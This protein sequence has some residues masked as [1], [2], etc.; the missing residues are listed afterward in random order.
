MTREQ[1]FD[2]VSVGGFDA[3]WVEVKR[4]EEQ[5]ERALSAL[6]EI[7]KKQDDEWIENGHPEDGDVPPWQILGTYSFIARTAIKDIEG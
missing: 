1:F 5:L 2:C 3:C 6:R 4:L 7:A